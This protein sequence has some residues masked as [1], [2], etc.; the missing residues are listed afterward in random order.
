MS[1]PI[2]KLL[3]MIVQA[4]PKAHMDLDVPDQAKGTWRL[5]TRVGRRWTVVLWDW[6]TGMFGV[7]RE[8]VKSYGLMTRDK[9]T[10][11]EESFSRIEDA[12][13]LVSKMLREEE[14]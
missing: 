4:F 1:N 7:S 14:P 12:F 3:D 13:E 6:D 11:P 10:V 9:E 2:V 5:T 8:E